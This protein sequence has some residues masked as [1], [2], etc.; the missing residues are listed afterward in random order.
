MLFMLIAVLDIFLQSLNEKKAYTRKV[1]TILVAEHS[2]DGKNNN[3][4]TNGGVPIFNPSLLFSI[5][6]E[7]CAEN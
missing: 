5:F 4:V 1:K 7:E 6:R 2:Q 3:Q